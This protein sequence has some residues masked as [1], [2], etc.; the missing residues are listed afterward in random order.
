MHLLRR[1]KHCGALLATLALTVLA[2]CVGCGSN[3]SS[4]G[5]SGTG[6]TT[7]TPTPTPTPTQPAAGT[8]TIPCDILGASGQTCQA[9][10]ATTRALFINYK[11]PLYQVTRQ[12]DG[13]TLD[14]AQLSDG[15][16]NAASQDSFCA[17][18]SCTITEIYDQSGNANHLVPAPPGGEA[19]GTGPGGY[20]LPAIANALPV[21]AGG[22]KVYGVYIS[23]GMG[24]RIDYTQGVPLGSKP[25]GTY[26]VSSGVH[27]NGGCCFD[28]GN[29][30]SNNLDNGAGHM[31]ALNVFCFS[32]PCV[33]EANLDMENGLYGLQP[34]AGGTQ[35]ISAMGTNDGT[36]A[37][38]LY[39]GNA[40]SGTLA[41][42]G[43]LALPAGYSP[44]QK[45]GSIL[46]GMGGDNSNWSIGSFFEGAVTSGVPTSATLS[47]VQQNIV[48]ARYSGM[49]PYHDGFAGGQTN[50]WTTYDGVWST[51]GASY[52]NTNATSN[53][54]K[55][56]TGSANWDD[57]TV[58]GDVQIISG[59]GNAGLL[60]RVTNPAT[61]ADGFNGYIVS[62]GIDGNLTLTREA[63]GATTL[64]S[65]AMPGGVQSG[66]WYHLT[67]QATGCALQVTAEPIGS[68]TVTSI[69]VSD[70][71]CTQLAGAI[72]LRSAQAA[73]Q[74]RNVDVTLGGSANAP[75]YAPF[76]A[77]AGWT[78]YAGTWSFSGD[79]Y[80]NSANDNQGDKVIGGPTVGDM[81]LTGDV[82]ITSTSGNAGFLFRATNPALGTDALQGYYAGVDSTGNIVIGLENNGWT[83]LA[84]APL[85]ASPSKTWYHLTVR[86]VGCQIEVTAQQV[87]M[88]TP[89]NDVTAT[90][91][92]F[93]KGQLGLR[94]FV[95]PAQWRYVSITTN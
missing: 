70:T 14:I 13:K 25:E 1:Q 55:A 89:A 30:E 52:T 93:A 42:N 24:Y 67:A 20:D 56:I 54:A 87:G 6:G 10:Y 62:V 22:H 80:I 46:L 94:S 34:I 39:M 41:S 61:G 90:D 27:F 37:Y 65:V 47:T 64:K 74:W 5:S 72:G 57:Y 86:A 33:P 83:Q 48:A 78:P 3:T 44:M 15:Y 59:S 75:Y 36:Q 73:A 66:V 85:N 2:C 40:Q 23:A 88:A 45:E 69:N 26:M 31:D 79:N 8:P 63:N 43:P 50:E 12:S 17:G 58:Q 28:F 82:Q 92:T 4:T 11:G 77:G 38:Q 91:C 60:L 9:A 18:T 19:H 29:A 95:T 7:P 68:T 76:A 84:S 21:S 51:N 49:L 32:S 35:F 53:G 16:A 71:G 81:T